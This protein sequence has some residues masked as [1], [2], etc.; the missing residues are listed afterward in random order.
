[1]CFPGKETLY[2]SHFPI[3]FK[4]I[5][6]IVCFGLRNFLR[7]PAKRYLSK[8]KPYVELSGNFFFRHYEQQVNQ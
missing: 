1:M 6:P 7:E 8:A 4:A 5:L 2:L 3:L